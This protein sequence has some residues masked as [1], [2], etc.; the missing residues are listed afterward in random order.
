MDFETLEKLKQRACEAKKIIDEQSQIRREYA[1]ALREIEMSIGEAL[2]EVLSNELKHY[3]SFRIGGLTSYEDGYVLD[4][5]PNKSYG[6]GG[7]VFKYGKLY[8]RM[9]IMVFVD[10]QDGYAFK[11]SI[12]FWQKDPL[13]AYTSSL[14]ISEIQTI[15]E[16]TCKSMEYDLKKVFGE[17]IFKTK[18]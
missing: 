11:T 3:N 17:D 9:N 6:L 7:L 8:L 14:D 12:P 13:S 10:E 5:F 15:W 2:F 1:S 16:N 4:I 18:E